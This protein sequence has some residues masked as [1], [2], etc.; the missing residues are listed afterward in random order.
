MPETTGAFQNYLKELAE[1]KNAHNKD[2]KNGRLAPAGLDE[3]SPDPAEEEE[4]MDKVLGD[5]DETMG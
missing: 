4:G 3:F 2:S 1:N 5:Q